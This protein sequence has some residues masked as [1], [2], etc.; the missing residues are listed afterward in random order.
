LKKHVAGSDW[1]PQKICPVLGF[2]KQFWLEPAVGVHVTT[3]V[4]GCWKQFCGRLVPAAHTAWPAEL[5]KHVD[6]RTVPAQIM[7]PVP[8]TQPPDP[9]PEQS[10][11]PVKGFTTHPEVPWPVFNPGQIN[12]PVD[13]SVKQPQPAPWSTPEQFKSPVTGSVK[14]P[15]PRGAV[16]PAGAGT[17]TVV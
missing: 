9:V 1:P 12:S 16:V 8:A 13:G 2:W 6:G 4:A 11:W 7:P 3:P 10:S 14:Q 15:E 17:L 5:K